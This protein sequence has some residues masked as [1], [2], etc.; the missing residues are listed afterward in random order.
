MSPLTNLLLIPFCTIPFLHDAHQRRRPTNTLASLCTR[1]RLFSLVCLHPCL[2][3]LSPS[4]SPCASFSCIG[5]SCT[6]IS[7]CLSCKRFGISVGGEFFRRKNSPA[8]RRAW[9]IAFWGTAG[10]LSD[11][12][13]E[14]I[15]KSIGW[16]IHA[17]T[18]SHRHRH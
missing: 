15:S 16:C 12:K 1:L 2:F 8:T 13:I 6:R 7:G 17:H 11:L 9:G 4:C 5:C 18:G 14:G 3:C 10:D